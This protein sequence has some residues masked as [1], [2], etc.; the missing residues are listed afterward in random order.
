MRDIAEWLEHLGLGE[1]AKAFAKNK[2]DANVLL[3][4]T[5]DDLKEIGVVAVG[6]RRKLLGAIAAL[7]RPEVA[8][9]RESVRDAEL[10]DKPTPGA[11]AERRQLTVM[12]CDLVGSTALSAKLDPEEMRD[13]IRAYQNSVAGEIARFEGHLAKFMG[14]GVLAYFGYPRAHEDEVERSVR[15]GLAV[16]EAVD[17]LTA[18]TDQPLAARIGIA[19]GLVVVG[20]LAGEGAAEK[21]A[22]V[23]ETPN[24]A[25]RLQALAEPGEVVI[26]ASTRQLLGGLFEYGDLGTHTLKGFAEPVQAWRVLGESAVEG[27]FEALRAGGV[28]PLVGREEELGLLLRRWQQAKEGEGQVV[29]LSGEAGIGKSRISQALHERLADEPHTRLR[30]FCSPYYT[31]SAFYPVISQLE[32]AAGMQR[33]DSTD[34]RLDKLETL[35]R[36]ARRNISEAM[37][38]IATL[39]SIPSQSRFPPLFVTPQKQKAKTL[40]ILLDQL[41]GLAEAQ[42]VLQ[43]VEDAHWIDPTSSEL[44]QL[45]VDRIQHLPVLLIIT[46]RSDFTPPWTGHSHVTSLTLNRLSRSQGAAIVEQVAGGK[47]L[48]DEILG[49]VLAKSD[50]VPLFV[51]ELTRTVLESDLLEERPD[52]YAMCRPMPPLAIPATLQDSLMARLDRLASVKEVAQ[53]GAAIGRSF[54]Y[55]LLAAVS[56]HD[57]RRLREALDALTGAELVF[58]RGTPPDATYM[59]KHALVQDTAYETLLISRRQ[60]LHARIAQSLERQFADLAGSQPEIVAHHY[61]EAGLAEPAIE[62]WLRAGQ[63]AVASSANREAAAHF[64]EAMDLLAMLPKGPERDRRE[65]DVLTALG[66]QL[67]MTKGIVSHAVEKTYARARSLSRSIGDARQEFMSLWGLWHLNEMRAE[68]KLALSLADELMTLAEA[69]GNTEFRLQAHHAMWSSLLFLGDLT[70]AKTHAEQG[71]ALYDREAHRDHVHLFGAHDPGVC[72]EQM[73]ALV[74]AVRGFPERA[75]EHASAGV[76]LARDLDQASSLAVVHFFAG[77]TD[78]VLH[79]GAAAAAHAQE[80][81]NVAES[82]GLLP[83]VQMGRILRGWANA[84]QGRTAEGV[85]EL[86]TVLEPARRKQRKRNLL[87]VYLGLLADAHARGGQHDDGLK[88]VDE[89]L[90]RVETQDERLWEAELLRIKAALL[91]ARSAATV[92]QVEATLHK[93]IALARR[94][95][96]KTFELRAAMDLARLWQ[97]QGKAKEARDLLAPL[98]GWYTEG[99]ETP[100]LTKARRLLDELA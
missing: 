78:Q 73:S 4:L 7:S 15:A 77:L 67:M 33:D 69:Q 95:S 79:R 18:P 74:L 28:M 45:V 89:A 20:D 11:P 39:L 31:N 6:D 25:A 29:L 37:P 70:G 36:Q 93:A 53:I 56:D 48:P 51:E 55:R 3:S 81:I 59:F 27:R 23:G 94:Q 24:L 63:L 82:A 38:F 43:I 60:E 86:N 21:Q 41:E 66:P 52:G 44:F 1:Y 84:E 30:Y 100:V 98:Y 83:F 19:T 68:W 62:Y 13:V 50:G 87:P 85:A 49:Q 34:A 16:A 90:Q 42:P 76:A 12:F 54:S 14:D 46:F 92:S 40:E 58:R 26:A 97:S 9:Q 99:F 72:A 8:P 5:G 64:S 75:L 71:L 88:A 80:A 57:D 65:L 10:Q 32:R 91:A 96:A 61:T 17:R 22:V 47:P 2:I 35:L